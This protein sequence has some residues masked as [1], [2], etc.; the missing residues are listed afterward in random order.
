MKFVAAML[1]QNSTAICLSSPTEMAKG[2]AVDEAKK[3]LRDKLQDIREQETLLHSIINETRQ[4]VR[5]FL[6]KM[7]KNNKQINH[8]FVLEFFFYESLSQSHH[9]PKF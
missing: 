7:N 2:S 8:F 5:L 4:E 6:N 1:T 3:R 9:T